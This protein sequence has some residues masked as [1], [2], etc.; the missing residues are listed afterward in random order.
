M[1]LTPKQV[2]RAFAKCHRRLH[3]D[4]KWKITIVVND[5][6]SDEDPENR[7]AYA[8]VVTERGYNLAVLTVNSWHIKS[9]K[10]L[11]RCLLHEAGHLLV[12]ERGVWTALMCAMGDRFDTLGREMLE[13]VIEQYTAA[14]I[15][16]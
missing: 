11:N 5:T 8:H 7:D 15:S 1:K 12:D 6:E 2:A 13:G 10:H 4:P 3:L 16:K 14:L 9:A